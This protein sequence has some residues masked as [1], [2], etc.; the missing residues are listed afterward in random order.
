MSKR[1][2]ILCKAVREGAMWL[3]WADLG[4]GESFSTL[5]AYVDTHTHTSVFLSSRCVQVM[6]DPGDHLNSQNPNFMES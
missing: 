6:K 1:A 4:E 3:S 5:P 2:A